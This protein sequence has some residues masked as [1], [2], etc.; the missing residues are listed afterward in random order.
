MCEVRAEAEEIY[1]AIKITTET[2]CVVFVGYERWPK[3]QLTIRTLT[4]VHDRL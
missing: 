1:D 2:Y 3:E 4:V